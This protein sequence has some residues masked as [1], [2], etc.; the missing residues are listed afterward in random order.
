MPYCKECGYEYTQGVKFCPDCQSVLQEGELLVCDR[1]NEPVTEDAMFCVHCGIVLPWVDE[2]TARAKC[3]IHK[4]SVATGC[5]VICRKMV[6]DDCS[7]T[8]QGKIFCRDDERVKTAFNWVVACTTSTAYEAEMVCANLKGADIPSMVLSQNDS[9]Y[10]T[11]VGNLA[12]TEVMVPKE[13]L[14][15]AKRFLRALE[16]EQARRKP[17]P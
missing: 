14:D 8:R 12:V 10:V 5:C 1:C 3:E 15:E 9:M 2:T 11:T 17:S 13:S 6:C 16:A 7:V 4:E